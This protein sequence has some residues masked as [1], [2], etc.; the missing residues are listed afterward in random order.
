MLGTA[1]ISLPEERNEVKEENRQ[2]FEREKNEGG[3]TGVSERRRDL[4]AGGS[5]WANRHVASV[6]IQ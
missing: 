1:H 5:S 6:C 3:E 4:V 2:E